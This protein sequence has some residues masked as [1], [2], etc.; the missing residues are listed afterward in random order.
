MLT[1]IQKNMSEKT[2]SLGC[3][4]ISKRIK[5]EVTINYTYDTNFETICYSWQREQNSKKNNCIWLW[6]DNIVKIIWHPVMLW[7][8]DK[9]ITKWP[10]YF[11][12]WNTILDLRID[13]SLPIDRQTDECIRY[14][15]SYIKS[16]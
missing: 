9:I 5:A 1:A 7:D 6:I 13:K 16:E 14:I 10:D 8:C 12:E 4:C 11:D 3:R 15:Y 2:L